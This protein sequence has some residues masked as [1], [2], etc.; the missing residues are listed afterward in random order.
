MKHGRT[1]R[2]DAMLFVAAVWAWGLSAAYF[3]HLAENVGAVLPYVPTAV[4]AGPGKLWRLAPALLI[5]LLAAVPLV[6]TLRSV[7][8]R[9]FR[10]LLIVALVVVVLVA[11]VWGG[12][13][14]VASREAA[15]I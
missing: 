15:Q 4:W 13:L 8:L 10:P 12:A 1:A 9:S 11:F 2:P 5:V 14:L 3:W 7:N 6:A